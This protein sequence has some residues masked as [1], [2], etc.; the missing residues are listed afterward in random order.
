[1]LTTAVPRNPEGT[2]EALLIV[3]VSNT[4]LDFSHDGL[5]FFYEAVVSVTS[6]LPPAV[7]EH[8]GVIV[9]VF[10]TNFVNSFPSLNLCR[11]G[12]L[13]PVEALLSRTRLQ[14]ISPRHAP[15]NVRSKSV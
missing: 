12:N 3:E 14:C 2:S 7:P 11:F 5:L 9:T 15:G 6:L 13:E 1:L 10:G 4:G 8:G